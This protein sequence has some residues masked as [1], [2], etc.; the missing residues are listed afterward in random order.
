[1]RITRWAALGILAF[2]VVALSY[3][4]AW[5]CIDPPID[6]SEGVPPG[7]V[8][9]RQ[10]DTATVREL[11]Q[12]E[13]RLADT[14]KAGDCD[15]WGAMLAPEWS[16]IHI[17]GAVIPKIE[18]L[19]VCKEE[20]PTFSELRYDDLSVRVFRDS[21]VVTGKATATV[22]GTNPVT[23]LLRFTDVFVRCD[24]RWLI[25]A[26]HATRLGS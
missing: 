9:L 23:I 17:T 8:A 15:A 25:V 22:A 16:V 20:R 6:T 4:M 1:M 21:A 10:P 14:Y 7:L 19:R 24:G 11:E 12:I 3:R 13:Q 5:A 2:A 26:S 18:A